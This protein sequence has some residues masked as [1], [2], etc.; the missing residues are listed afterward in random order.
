[1]KFGHG[2]VYQ[3]FIHFLEVSGGCMEKTSRGDVV[4]LAGNPG[5]IVVDEGFG[6]DLEDFL[7]AAGAVHSGVDIG[8]GLVFAQG[9]EM[10]AHRDSVAQIAERGAGEEA[11]QRL[12]TAQDDLYG[13]VGL[14]GGA[15]DQ[16]QMG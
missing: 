12:L 10:A 2:V 14:E 3:G 5:C 6:L 4:D 13:E 11:G 1:M 7:G 9:V 15:Q 8:Q 16:A